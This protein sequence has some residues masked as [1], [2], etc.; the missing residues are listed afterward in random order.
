MKTLL[1]LS[2]PLITLIQALCIDPLVGGHFKISITAGF[3]TA[4]HH[5][6]GYSFFCFEKACS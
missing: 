5:I 1:P 2:A 6:A 4:R 3:S